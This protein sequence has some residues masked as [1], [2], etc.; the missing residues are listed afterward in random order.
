MTVAL[1]KQETNKD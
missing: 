1:Q